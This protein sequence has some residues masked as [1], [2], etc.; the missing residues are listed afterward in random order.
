MKKNATLCTVA[1]LLSTRRSRAIGSYWN[2][3][4][5]HVHEIEVA[6]EVCPVETPTP[7]AVFVSFEIN[8]VEWV[9]GN[10]GARR[11]TDDSVELESEI[12][13]DTLID[14]LIAARDEARRAGTFEGR[15]PAVQ[16]EA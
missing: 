9:G 7:G 13:L 14:A 12:E 1:D 4:R 11:Q 15:P 8:R 6:I 16:L 10:Q 5:S 3:E 2:N